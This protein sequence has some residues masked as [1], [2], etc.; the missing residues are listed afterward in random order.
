MSD[1]VGDTPNPAP[2]SPAQLDF[3]HAEMAEPAG[4]HVSCEACKRPITTESW[5][6]LGKVLCGSCHEQVGR[7]AGEARGGAALGKAF[8]LGGLVAL[9]SGIGYA[10]FVGLTQIQFALIT[11]GIGWAVGRAVQKGTRGFGSVRH[12]VL[13]VALTYFASSMGYLPAIF[14]AFSHQASDT[15]QT[16]AKPA[17]ASAPTTAPTAAPAGEAP[18]P[19][20]PSAGPTEPEHGI[21]ASLLILVGLT[22]A[23]MLA[24][25][26]IEI[27]GGFSGILGALIIFF[28][29]RTAWRVSKGVEA[30]MTGPHRVGAP[31]SP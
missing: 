31:P 20:A 28:G 5:Q 30:T 23:F 4:A 24:A 13:A 15:H 29:L 10:I 16:D 11:I 7:A 19:P 1:V 26:L 22:T 27:T 14:K 25:P 12:Q 18:P 3:E 9:G 17:A 8:L 2:E 21:V 6:L